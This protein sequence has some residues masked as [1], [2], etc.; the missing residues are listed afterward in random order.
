MKRGILPVFFACAGLVA[1]CS[2][3]N[4]ERRGFAGLSG[5]YDVTYVGGLVF[6]TSSDRDE[7]QVL[8]A[9]DPDNRHFIPAPNPLQT[10]AI[11]VLDRPDALAR[12][13]GYKADGSALPGPYVYA[14]SA[15]SAGVSVVAADPSRL[16]QVHQ[17]TAPSLVTAFAARSPA[18]VPEGAAPGPSVLYFAIQDPDAPFGEDT[19]G[20]RVVRQ[21]IPG[22][23]ALDA[24]EVVPAPVTL[25]CLLPGESVQSMAVLPNNQLVVA[26]RQA[27]AL[28]GRTLLVTDTEPTANVDCKTPT[29]A[30]R[31]LSAGFGNTPVRFVVSHPRVTIRADDPGT[32]NV[33]ELQ[34]MVA[35]QFVFGLKDELACGG[36]EACTGVLAVDTATGQTATDLSGATMLPIR[37]TAGIPTG[38]T[39]IPNASV[40]FSLVDKDG[41]QPRGV[42]NPAIVPLLAIMPSSTGTI[43]FFSGNDRREFDLDTRKPFVNVVV[44]DATDTADIAVEGAA[45]L[46]N[47]SQTTVYPCD[48]ANPTGP[49]VTRTALI[50]GSV[51]GGTFRFI[52]QGVF[53]GMFNVTR[54]LSTPT[55]FEV[56]QSADVNKQVRVGD[57]IELVSASTV[58]TTDLVVSAVRPAATAG[59]VVLETTTAI[60][61]GCADLPQFSVLAS[62]S[63]P[64]L[65]T[66]GAGNLLTRDAETVQGGYEIPTSYYFH[67]PDF[68]ETT[69]LAGSA[70][71]CQT[72]SD[73]TVP[74][75]PSPPP[76]LVLRVEGKGALT[77]GQSLLVTVGTGVLNYFFGIS[78]TT[79]TGLVFYTLP[80]TVT[81]SL[82]GGAGL[83]YVVYPSADGIL[84]L[85]L[86]YIESN[87]L[88]SKYLRA[89][90]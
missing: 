18:E 84:Q 10:L 54:D 57:L 16:V 36:A 17:F 64:F 73:V 6:V 58:C 21:P 40:N 87:A 37:P 35:G 34:E 79:Q 52:Y 59:R 76:P 56:P 48:P 70:A 12:D 88:N 90:E 74:L 27:T 55:L 67:P 8:D 43:T 61:G 39:L 80:G 86:P 15:G 3:S 46:V 50:E 26:T 38:L 60:P 14:R 33:N 89:F 81:A 31:D 72:S 24:G 63:Q 13:T 53:P 28:T 65:L 66:D 62:G 45:S 23:E 78:T 9:R 82:A 77:R 32:P 1:G 83:A 5:T 69:T 49:K 2:D 68:L 47:V 75:Y 29:T 4:E 30:T 19:G 71:A 85:N 22:P 25:F 44:R 41:L 51:P 42:S 20:A 11:P 7:L